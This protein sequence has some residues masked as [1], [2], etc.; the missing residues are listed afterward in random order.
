MG[1]LSISGMYNERETQGSPFMVI[2]PSGPF[3][4]SVVPDLKLNWW[5][6]TEFKLGRRSTVFI[7]RSFIWPPSGPAVEALSRGKSVDLSIPWK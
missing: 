6:S 3:H 7:K 5:Q 4:C 1:M 2:R